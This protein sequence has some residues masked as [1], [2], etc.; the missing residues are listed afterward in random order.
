MNGKGVNFRGSKQY[1]LSSQPI[2]FSQLV[3][4]SH[5]VCPASSEHHLSFRPQNNYRDYTTTWI[6]G[7][8]RRVE[9]EEVSQ[10]PSQTQTEQNNQSLSSLVQSEN[11]SCLPRHIIPLSNLALMNWIPLSSG[12]GSRGCRSASSCGTPGSS[13]SCRHTVISSVSTFPSPKI[14]QNR[15]E[16]EGEKE[17]KRLTTQW[18][19]TS[20][21][22]HPPLFQVHE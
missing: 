8:Q 18:P 11:P 16:R 21:T 3:M 20:Q 19:E 22:R 17:K 7:R 4:S 15:A 5:N 10:E 13:R 1:E 2:A 9:K 14:N 6:R 12:G